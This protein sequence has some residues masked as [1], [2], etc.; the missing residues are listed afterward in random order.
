MKQAISVEEEAGNVETESRKDGH[1]RSVERTLAILAAMNRVPVSTIEALHGVTGLPKPTLVRF[2]KTLAKAG[3]VTHSPDHSGYQLTSLVTSLSSGYHGDPLIVEAARPWAVQL[4]RRLK[5]PVSIAVLSGHWVVVRLSTVAESPI[6]PFH[7]TINMKLG[8]FS[9]GL[10]K[11]YMAWLT[12]EQIEAFAKEIEEREPDERPY[13]ADRTALW[14]HVALLRKQG[15]ALRD[16]KAEPNTSNTLAV[17]IFLNDQVKATIG[18]TF[19]RSVVRTR[20]QLEEFAAALK[21]ASREISQETMRLK[22]AK[23]GM[24]L[25]AREVC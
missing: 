13:V 6:S 18:I 5:W 24:P 15:Y 25:L 19:F 7:A 14:E 17:P 3:Y 22:R 12:D 8:L 4:T 16:F 20:E 21:E 10:G 2:L 1:I 9:R 11:A 23:N